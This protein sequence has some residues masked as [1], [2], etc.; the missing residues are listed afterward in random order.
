M[1][2]VSAITWASTSFV[3]GALVGVFIGASHLTRGPELHEISPLLLADTK[4]MF[5]DFKKNKIIEHIKLPV[6]D[7]YYLDVG[8]VSLARGGEFGFV[9]V[10]D[11]MRYFWIEN[12]N[13]VIKKYDEN[14]LF[15]TIESRY[16]SQLQRVK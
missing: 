1:N 12:E 7:G 16:I 10:A 8:I 9:R 14:H 3:A 13:F 4:P 6:L 5:L 15:V 2:K 11:P